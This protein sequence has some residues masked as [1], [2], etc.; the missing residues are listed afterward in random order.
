MLRSSWGAS[1]A[2]FRRTL[3]TSIPPSR[4][5]NLDSLAKGLKTKPQVVNRNFQHAESASALVSEATRSLRHMNAFHLILFF[6]N[7]HAHRDSKEIVQHRQGDPLFFLFLG[8]FLSCSK[9]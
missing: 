2:L 9:L 7:L 4:A 8:V 1:N 3:Q 6:N 5:L